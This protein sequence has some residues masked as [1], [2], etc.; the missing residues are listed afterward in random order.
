MP[1]QPGKEF[2]IKKRLDRL[3]GKSRF[4]RHNNNNNNDNNNGGDNG[5]DLFGPGGAPPPMPTIEDFLDGGPPSPP[6]PPTARFNLWNNLF[7]PNNTEPVP[8]PDFNVI[9]A[10]TAPPNVST[11]G[12]GNNLFGSQAVTAVRENKRKT[13]QEVWIA[14]QYARTWARRWFSKNIR[15]WGKRPFRSQSSSYKKEE[16][17]EILKDLMDEYNVEDIKDTIDETGQVPE[18]IYFFMVKKART[19]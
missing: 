17:Y 6:P 1:S 12:I 5:P 2:Q 19:L 9:P 13:Q 11:S 18:S 14:W 7:Q 10:R 3:R 4:D 15:D 16:K 8:P